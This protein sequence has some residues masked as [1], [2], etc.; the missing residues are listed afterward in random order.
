[1]EEIRYDEN[2]IQTLDSLEC[3]RLR[4]G[5]Y[6][7]GPDDSSSADGGI[8][9]LLKE[10]LNNSISEFTM[11]AGRI[12]DIEISDNKAEVCDYGRGIPLGKVVD[13]IFKTN[14]GG[15]HDSRVFKKSIGLNGMSIKAVNI[16][17]SYSEV[18]SVRDNQTRSTPFERRI[19]KEGSPA[20]KTQKRQGT[21]VAFIP[22]NTIFKSFKFRNEYVVHI[23]KNYVY[24]NPG[25]TANH[26]SE[27]Y[28][29]E[30]G[31]KDLLTEDND[32]ED[33]LYPVTHLKGEGIK[34]AISHSKT[35]CSEEYHSSING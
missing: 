12:I 33:F 35:Q 18:E 28:Y 7:G 3:V 16:L 34:V 31:L 8:Y 1:M 15:R 2:S 25:P 14:A 17:S 21:S 4:P 22:D 24:L 27:K 32:E 29:S 26:S 9:V 23:P 13:V 19:I 5:M 11:G 30:S 20:G 10:V 6:I